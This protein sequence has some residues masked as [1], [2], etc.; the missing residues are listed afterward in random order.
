M[1]HEHP[2]KSTPLELNT[3]SPKKCIKYNLPPSIN[4]TPAIVVEK[5]QAHSLRG[6]T[7]LCK[8]IPHTKYTDTCAIQNCYSCN[9]YHN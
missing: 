2:A 6:F 7:T 5:I 8:T 1:I 4:A 9:Q 3:N